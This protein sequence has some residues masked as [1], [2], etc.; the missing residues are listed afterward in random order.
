[1]SLYKCIKPDSIFQCLWSSFTWS[2]RRTTIHH[3]QFSN[4]RFSIISWHPLDSNFIGVFFS[5]IFYIKNFF[6]WQIN[7]F[8]IIF[9]IKIKLL[10]ALNGQAHCLFYVVIAT[11]TVHVLIYSLYLYIGVCGRDPEYQ[12]SF[13]SVGTKYKRRSR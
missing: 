11:Y 2:M 12:R 4:N 10:K 9:H 5:E 1:M 13:T 7:D 3:P 8:Y 6:R